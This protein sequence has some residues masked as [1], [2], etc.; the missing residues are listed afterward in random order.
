M[1]PVLGS[2]SPQLM[3]I[4][5]MS[6]TNIVVVTGH[7]G[8]DVDFRVFPN[9]GNGVSEFR[10]AVNKHRLNK[11]T[12]EFDTYTTWITIKVFGK[13]AERAKEKLFKGAKVTV[14]GELAED[15]WDDRQTGQKRSKLYIIGN[16][17]EYLGSGARDIQTENHNISTPQGNFQSEQTL[18]RQQPT[19][20]RSRQDINT[21]S[22]L[23]MQKTGTTGVV[24]NTK[25]VGY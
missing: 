5:S 7:L 17:L 6:N 20:G 19:Q 11:H 14:T 24:Q 22:R 1:F 18:D 23:P 13:L 12:D 3:E 21:Q 9:T 10:I 25:P 2:V 4:N 8:D 16:T 15:S